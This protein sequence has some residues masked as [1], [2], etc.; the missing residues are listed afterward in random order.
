MGSSTTPRLETRGQSQSILMLRADKPIISTDPSLSIKAVNHPS[1]SVIVPNNNSGSL[2]KRC[3]QSLQQQVT[4]ERFEVIVV[5]DGSTDESAQ[6]ASRFPGVTL[7]RQEHMGASAARNH[8][9]Q[10][11]RGR[12]I[13]FLDSD[14]SAQSNWIATI[15]EPLIRQRA[16]VTVGRFISSQE[17]TIARL[18]QFELEERFMRMERHGE[19]D[20][21][22]S[23]TCGF[24]REIIE[25]FPFDPTFTKLEDV[26]LSFRLARTG[27]TIRYVS[28]AIVDHHHPDRLWNYLAR[29]YRYGKWAPALYRRFPANSLRDDSTPGHRRVQLGLVLLALLTLPFVPWHGVLVL[30]IA[31]ALSLPAASRV[32]R[33]HR[34]LAMLY[35]LFT[36]A[37]NIAFLSGWAVGTTS[38]MLHPQR[39]KTKLSVPANKET[40]GG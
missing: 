26:E 31:A 27:I 19:V 23:A 4:D 2:L 39:V 17:K 9:L 12:L 29:K 37:G 1:V 14:C 3:L 15:A 32:W 35:P 7:V 13:L 30:L 21:L 28:T 34:T 20:F 16:V 8:G 33:S 40:R 10:A 38:Q 36:L 22:N 24:S 11:A 18:V 6:S 25:R 5:D